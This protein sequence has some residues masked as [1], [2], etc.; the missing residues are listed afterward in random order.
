MQFSRSL[1][2]LTV[3][4]LAASAA[5]LAQTVVLSSGQG[6]QFSSPQ[7]N[8]VPWTLTRTTTTVQ[9]LA[10]G[11]TITNTFT[12]KEARDSEGRAYSETQQTL[13]V[14]ADGQPIDLTNYIVFDPIARVHI[15][16]QNRT[17][18]ANVTHMPDPQASQQRTQPVQLPDVDMP[19]VPQTGRP[20]QQQKSEDLGVRTIAGIEAKGT[21]ATGV[22]PVGD[23]GNDRPI[24]IVT[25]NWVS[26][27]YNIQLLTITD[28]PRSGK[29]T[30]EVTE[31]QPGEPDPKLFQIPEGYTVRDHAAF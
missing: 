24:T 1:S 26:T 8:K 15:T 27:Q 29:R 30:D 16:W 5:L 6:A 19:R 22:I 23:W 20:T 31:F 12:V 18:I 10:D 14:R 25:E 21:R 2:M 7:A 28:D 11:T 17:K 13:H 3:L 9:T 4:P